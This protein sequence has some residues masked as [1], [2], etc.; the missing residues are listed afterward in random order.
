MEGG[1][2]QIR[3]D[4]WHISYIYDL[5]SKHHEID[6]NPDFG[7]SVIWDDK[8]QSLLIESLMLR[9]PI[10]P[11]YLAE[12]E[13]G[14]YQV[15][16]GL[17]RLTAIRRFLDNELRLQ[18]LEYITDQE[19]KY[20]ET[21]E[22]KI[23]IERQ[24]QRVILQT[25]I[26]ISI[27]ESRSSPEAKYN[28]FRR[29]NTK[30]SGL[31][32]QE[33]R[34]SLSFPHTREF[35]KSLAQNEIFLELIIK[36]KKTSQIDTHELVL[37]FICFWMWKVKKY[38]DW[39]LE[40]NIQKYYDHQLEK[41]NHQKEF[42]AKEI[43]ASFENA[44][45]ISKHLFGDFAFRKCLPKD[46]F[47]GTKILPVNKL[48]FII[49]SVLLSEKKIY[50]IQSR[51]PEGKLAEILANEFEADRMLFI[52]LNKMQNRGKVEWLFEKLK[53]FL[54]NHLGDKP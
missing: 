39:K 3:N 1:N 28:I 19:N 24:Y 21:R 37:G 8:M 4:R 49:I 26:E 18:S 53:T 45:L 15:I 2:I 16:D 43:Q 52:T 38:E 48:L 40:G 5:I 27:I 51:V 9:I 14:R 13:N 20:F 29:L 46:L 44:M 17:Q 41:I 30:S 31:S 25:T 6:L 11:L 10:P 35:L 42:P 23:G 54:S 36:R 12:N 7:R 33:I 32:R 34:N 22:N 47:R 50:E